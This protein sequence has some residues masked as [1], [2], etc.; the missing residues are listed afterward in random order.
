MAYPSAAIARYVK[1]DTK[2]AL[3]ARHVPWG[4]LFP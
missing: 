4:T 1:P 2:E 3:E